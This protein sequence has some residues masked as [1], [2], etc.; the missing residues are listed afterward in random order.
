LECKLQTHDQAITG[1][2]HAIRELMTPPVPPKKQRIG[3]V[4]TDD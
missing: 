1:I 2:L 4:Q 3:F